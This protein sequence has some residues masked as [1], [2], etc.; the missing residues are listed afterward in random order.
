MAAQ[1][2]QFQGI[3]RAISD[4]SSAGACEELINLRPTTG[5]LV[6][7]KPFRVKISGVTYDKVYEHHAGNLMN[8]IAIEIDNE[9]AGS[10]SIFLLSPD[11]QSRELI[12]EV[13]GF[14]HL[15]PSDIHFAYVGNIILFS[16]V[17]E[18]DNYYGNLSYIW[19]GTE[20]MAQE[21]Q[22]P[23]I[24][25]SIRP[26]TAELIRRTGVNYDQNT[27]Q[28]EIID[29]LSSAFNAVQEL[30]KLKCFGTVLIAIAFKTK[31]NKTFWTGRW[32][33]YD[34]FSFIKDLQIDY[35]GG[36]PFYANNPSMATKTYPEGGF[37]VKA[38]QLGSNAVYLAG[39]ELQMTLS[40]ISGWD[41]DTSII[42]SVEVYASRPQP[43]VDPANRYGETVLSN[44]S[45][46]T[47]LPKIPAKEMDLEN[48]L[49]YLQKS[50][51][52][53]ELTSG[54]YSFTLEF[55]GNIQTTNKTLDVDAGMVMRFGNILAYNARFHFYDSVAKEKIG[56]PYFHYPSDATTV[57][58]YIFVVYNDGHKDNTLYV[59]T[60]NLPTAGPSIIIAPSLKIKEVIVSWNQNG[61]TWVFLH[62]PMT[63]S[64]RY[65]YTIN[66]G[67][68]T[69]VVHSGTQPSNPTS[70]MLIEEPDAINVT[71]Q[72]NA[73][74][75]N[76]RNSY[77]APGRV[78]AVQPQMVAVRDVSYG[79]YPLNVFTNRG[80][81]ALLQG[82]GIVLYGSFRSVSNL[83]TTSNSIPTE[84]GTFF[85][86]AGALWMVA[87]NA[88]VLIS[89]ALSLGP[90][91]FI[92]TCSGYQSI[93]N[94]VYN[95]KHYE[96][97]V[98]FEDYVN[99]ATLSYNRFRNELIISNPAYQY[100]YVLSLKYRQWFKIG[101]VLSQDTPGATIAEI[102]K[103]HSTK[104]VAGITAQVPI[105]IDFLHDNRDGE[106]EIEVNLQGAPDYIINVDFSEVS[107]WQSYVAYVIRVWNANYGDV[108]Q[109]GEATHESG[110]S[111]AYIPFTFVETVPGVTGIDGSVN[112]LVDQS[113][114]TEKSFTFSEPTWN[115][116]DFSDEVENQSALV[117][118]QSRPFSMSYQYIHVH[119]IVAMVRAALSASDCL[120]V[121]LYG[122]DDL[123]NW[124]LLT[125]ADRSNAQISQ[126]RTPSAARSWR[127]YT[128]CIGGTTPNDTDFGPVIMDYQPVVRRIG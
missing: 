3:N 29:Q 102:G 44:Q 121:S 114:H 4:F 42:K 74:V 125:Y 92:R 38:E 107:D 11:G 47:I 118:L 78:L 103:N 39:V 77:L 67:D 58:R 27:N 23:Q 122:S 50:I 99:G 66:L 36:I 34:P 12:D 119:S 98:P 43:Y 127:Y 94:T 30:N 51:P 68:Y 65:N 81:Y 61:Q 21:A 24:T 97:V 76:V 16:I 93:A 84:S 85:I 13:Q 113:T 95:V 45:L 41:E 87:G 35:L 106:L 15:S 112:L 86:A 108:I 55:G 59:G 91:K 105:D 120:I 14:R 9:E 26:L 32:L 64:E 25:A 28:D 52:L 115:V 70:F 48:Q 128:L 104:A 89:D 73:F 72:Y 101:I 90:H 2:L 62:Y 17:D 53:S 111:Y 1:N 126:I 19:N 6:P 75:F 63:A 22:S 82:S 5:G 57:Q 124:K 20:Y 71:E 56:M 79:D 46:F 8:Y 10:F 54:S 40:Q 60:A 88:A 83:V 80:V 31:D 49:L 37:I 33:V 116:V 100:S 109:A 123:Q 69:Q 96:S 18:E 117:H 7:V 110:S